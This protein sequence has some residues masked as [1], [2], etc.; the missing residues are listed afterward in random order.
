M[1]TL[2]SQGKLLS[3]KPAGTRHRCNKQNNNS[4]RRGYRISAK[5]FRGN[6]LKTMNAMRFISEKTYEF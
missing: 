6:T 2:V 1:K 4:H 5:I 3:W